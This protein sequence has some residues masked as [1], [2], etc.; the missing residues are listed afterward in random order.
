MARSFE[1]AWDLIAWG[2]IAWDT[3]CRRD[4]GR[5]TLTRTVLVIVHSISTVCRIVRSRGFLF[6]V[7]TLP[8][9]KEHANSQDNDSHTSNHN[10]GYRTPR[11]A[12]GRGFR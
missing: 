6:G 2:L 7:R 10:A 4:S 9:E 5:M 3:V 12:G 1:L 8:E 11:E